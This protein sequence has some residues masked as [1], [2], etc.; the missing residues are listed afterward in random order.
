MQPAHPGFY[1]PRASPWPHPFTLKSDQDE[2]L[3][4]NLPLDG[5]SLRWNATCHVNYTVG[6][7]QSQHHIVLGRGGI[8][9]CRGVYCHTGVY[10][11]KV[12]MGIFAPDSVDCF[13]Q[14]KCIHNIHPW[15]AEC[16]LTQQTECHADCGHCEAGV[17]HD[18]ALGLIKYCR[19][20]GG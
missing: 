1:P 16:W 11:C 17:S 12:C 7:T 9:A 3:I 6:I 18:P 20:A 2:K 13:T 14:T 10:D 15:L 5:A 19:D 8:L 4:M